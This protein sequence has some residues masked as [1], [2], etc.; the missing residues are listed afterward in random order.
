M[1]YGIPNDFIKHKNCINSVKL[2]DVIQDK[3]K[4]LEMNRTIKVQNRM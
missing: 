2:L 4:L 1:G 3:I